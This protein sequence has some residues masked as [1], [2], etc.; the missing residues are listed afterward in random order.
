MLEADLAR[1]KK[2]ENPR[3]IYAKEVLIAGARRLG[4]SLTEIADALGVDPSTV[5]RRHDAVRRK[6]THNEPMAL[7]VENEAGTDDHEDK[8]HSIQSHYR[9]PDPEIP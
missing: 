7:H 9:K 6:M 4:C 1:Q 5:T 3:L 2:V 8:N